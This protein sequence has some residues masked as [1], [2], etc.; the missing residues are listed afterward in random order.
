MAN[1]LTFVELTGFK[2]LADMLRT[3]L[4]EAM[5]NRIVKDAMYSVVNRKV[6]PLIKKEIQ[7]ANLIHSGSLYH[8]I[9]IVK[10]DVR[11]KHLPRLVVGPGLLSEDEA[12]LKPIST[13]RRPWY[14]RFVEGGTK[15]RAGRGS[16][17]GRRFMLKAYLT[18]KVEYQQWLREAI[19]ERFVKWK[20]NQLKK[21]KKQSKVK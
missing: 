4:P 17:K 9:V 5:Q 18:I 21:A 14:A 16:V 19:A 20:A 7:E 13:Y 6:I 3:E 2:E 10:A 1:A 12:F 15:V 8:S 11:N